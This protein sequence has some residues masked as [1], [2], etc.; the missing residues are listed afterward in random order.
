[1][2]CNG[3]C[4]LNKKLAEDDKQNSETPAQKIADEMS[5][6]FFHPIAFQ[7]VVFKFASATP[8]YGYYKP[9]ALQT[10]IN[11]TFH[12]PATV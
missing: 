7:S 8:L 5:V 1:M 2:H 9:L 11:S 10:H 12:P 4:Q 3:H 6:F